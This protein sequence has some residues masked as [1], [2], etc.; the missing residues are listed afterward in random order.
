ME[1]LRK[2]AWLSWHHPKNNIIF[3]KI[4]FHFMCR[5]THIHIH[6]TAIEVLSRSQREYLRARRAQRLPTNNWVRIM[7]SVSMCKA[8]LANPVNTNTPMVHR[9]ALKPFQ[10]F[11]PKVQ[12][13]SEP[14]WAHIF[15]SL[16]IRSAFQLLNVCLHA[17]N[18]KLSQRNAFTA[19]HTWFFFSVQWTNI[20]FCCCFFVFHSLGWCWRWRMK[21]NPP[22]QRQQNM[23]D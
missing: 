5:H 10:S 14:N 13:F 7:E 21:K 6:T 20:F 12:H 16:H 3:R 15:K 2:S 11:T 18:W 22:S 19:L 9:A 8:N 23:S 17:E 1:W 4:W